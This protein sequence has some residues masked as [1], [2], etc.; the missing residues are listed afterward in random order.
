MDECTT[1]NTWNKQKE[2][3]C[4]FD[5]GL[6]ETSVDLTG[7]KEVSN[8]LLNTH[9]AF[10][11]DS[12]LSEISFSWPVINRNIEAYTARANCT[13]NKPKKMD[14]HCS[15]CIFECSSKLINSNNVGNKCCLTYD[16]AIK[17]GFFKDMKIKVTT[18]IYENGVIVGESKIGGYG[19]K[20][21]LNEN[22]YTR[23]R[24]K[25]TTEETQK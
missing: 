24:E 4:V 6:P 12:C 5:L 2:R 21:T 11:N 22:K 1:L 3:Q 14:K 17:S 20:I 16:Q 23:F 8:G 19:D 18:S 25:Q 13:K 15:R 10:R 7:M 9:S